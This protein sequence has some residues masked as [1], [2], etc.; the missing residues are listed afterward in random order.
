M[1]QLARY[2]FPTISAAIFMAAVIWLYFNSD[3]VL[4]LASLR[5][6]STWALLAPLFLNI[7]IMPLYAIRLAALARAK[8]AHALTIVV[9]GFG[10]NSLLP[11][12]LGDAYKIA[13]AYRFF[14]IKP[15]S[16]I[17]AVGMEKLYDIGALVLIGVAASQSP[18]FDT[19]RNGILFAAGGLLFAIVLYVLALRLI[20][21]ERFKNLL[22]C[23]SWLSRGALELRYLIRTPAVVSALLTTIG[24]WAVT[25]TAIFIYFSI[26]FPN[27]TLWDANIVCLIIA[28]A[29][30]IPGTPSGLGIMEA[31]LVIYL[32][33]AFNADID[34][35][36]A[37]AAAYRL[38]VMLPQ[39]LAALGILAWRF[40]AGR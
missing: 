8:G 21:N 5:S 24:I 20:E 40:T 31:A 13:Y 34:L 29:I 36:I 17:L 18:H 23:V 1:A 4:I 27:F 25:V 28:L 30:A 38:S 35:S 39:V 7:I 9:L 3:P 14:R 32:Q 6:V 11:F 33:Q 16:L 2:I 10:L 19:V 22:S 37:L 12:R 15:E 26:P